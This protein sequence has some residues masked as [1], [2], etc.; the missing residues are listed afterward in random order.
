MRRSREEKGRAVLHTVDPS[1]QR[2]VALMGGSDCQVEGVEPR[3][4]PPI[5]LRPR[6]Q[7]GFVVGCR[8]SAHLSRGDHVRLCSSETSG[9]G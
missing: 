8:M 1:M 5:G 2:E 6:L 9:H 3:G 4:L 7:F